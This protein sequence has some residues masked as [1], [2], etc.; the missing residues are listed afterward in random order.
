MGGL[1]I[2]QLSHI[3]KLYKNIYNRTYKYFT[4]QTHHKILSA[5]LIP[6]EINL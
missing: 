1:K 2:T 4:E 5:T 3:I 6:R